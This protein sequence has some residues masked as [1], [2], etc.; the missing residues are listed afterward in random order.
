MSRRTG[1]D[2]ELGLSG[3]ESLESRLVTKNV[4][5]TLH[6]KRE[7]RVDGLRARLLGLLDR[8]CIV[9]SVGVFSDMAIA[10]RG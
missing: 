2:D 5:S 10:S 6:N 7:A 3:T 9:A 1:N 4:L 8:G